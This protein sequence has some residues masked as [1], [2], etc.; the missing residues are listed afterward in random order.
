MRLILIIGVILIGAGVF[1]FVA[2]NWQAISKLGKLFIIIIALL[3]SH[4]GAWYLKEKLF[5]N[6]TSEVLH[7]LGSIIF[8]AGIF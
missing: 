5:Y 3:A 1:S 8:G 4:L 7:L 6:K 2:A